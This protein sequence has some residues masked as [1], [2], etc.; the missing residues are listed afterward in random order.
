MR[1]AAP[2]PTTHPLHARVSMHFRQELIQCPPGCRSTFANKV[3]SSLLFLACIGILIPSTARMVYGKHVITGTASQRAG[4]RSWPSARGASPAA[5]ACR[6][7]VRAAS[8][9]QRADRHVPSARAGWHAAAGLC[10][11][12]HKTPEPFTICWLLPMPC[13]AGRV[14]LNLSHGVAIL[15]VAM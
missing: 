10:M 12:K 4:G 15:L 8:S 11:L 7:C 9:E 6:P 14:L 1:A 2:V 5:R 3:S 13:A